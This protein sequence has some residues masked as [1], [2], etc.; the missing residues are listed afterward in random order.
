MPKGLSLV[1]FV[2]QH[3]SLRS[4][5]DTSKSGTPA[6]TSWAVTGQDGL[7]GDAGAEPIEAP[8]DARV[9]HLP[10]RGLRNDAVGVP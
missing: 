2:E 7:Q 4:L 1:R 9:S 10:D 6:R 3:Y 5:I 8:P